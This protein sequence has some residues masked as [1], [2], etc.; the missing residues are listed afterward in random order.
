M[1]M[2]LTCD[3]Q[4]TTEALGRVASVVSPRTPQPITL[5]VRV[6]AEEGHKLNFYATDFERSLRYTLLEPDVTVE[7]PGE[8][9]VPARKLSETVAMLDKAER[10][11]LEETNEGAK[12]S[13]GRAQFKFRGQSA[14]EFPPFPEFD[15]DDAILLPAKDLAYMADMVS[16]AIA[17]ER[18]RY[19]LNG[20]LF[21]V[22]PD[23]LTLVG[24]DGKRLAMISK[25][26]EIGRDFSNQHVIVPK[27][28]LD[29][30]TWACSQSSEVRLQIKENQL[31]AQTDTALLSTLL[32]NGRYPDFRQVLPDEGTLDKKAVLSRD[33][34]SLNLRRVEKFT[35]EDSMSVR[36]AFESNK[37][38]MT[39]RAPEEGEAEVAMDVDYAAD[40][41]EIGFDPHFL[42]DVLKVL[43]ADEI[44]IALRDADSAGVIHTQTEFDYLYLVMPTELG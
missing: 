27:K 21:E 40:P 19:S 39:S 22:R 37:L 42:L 16:F 26:F 1:A 6:T 17:S 30:L 4:R 20:V 11:K 44:V 36:F 32:V 31:L 23:S 5:N 35:T 9:C 14:G 34:F 24:S 28:G 8:I 12:L 7:Q 25:P 43:E 13:S 38:T 10:L 33:T 15:A 18:S 2:K 41:L 3:Q 29:L